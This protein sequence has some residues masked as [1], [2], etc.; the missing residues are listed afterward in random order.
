MAYIITAS[1]PRPHI[2]FS[3]RATLATWREIG[4]QRRALARVDARLLKDMGISE[5]QARTESRRW[6]WDTRPVPRN[7]TV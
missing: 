4:R 7:I 3:I 1:T 6:V 5:R 2:R